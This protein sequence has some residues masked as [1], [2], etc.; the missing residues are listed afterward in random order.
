MDF[1]DQEAAR[2]LSEMPNWLRAVNN[3]KYVSCYFE[4]VYVF[5]CKKMMF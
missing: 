4:I 3:G 2:M 1:C 5:V